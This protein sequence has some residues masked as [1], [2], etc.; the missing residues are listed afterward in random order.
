MEPERPI[1]NALRAYAKKR[2]EEAGMPL[3]LHPAT[4][5]LLQGEVARIYPG[6]KA[7]KP[8]TRGFLRGFWP[9]M[10]LSFGTLAVVAIILAVWLPS[11][12]HRQSQFELAKNQPNPSVERLASPAPAAA[13]APAA[14]AISSA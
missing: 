1:E 14:P 5:R 13:A 2:R 7:E 3:E 8:E 9:K 12:S 6:S 4:R 11:L 10:A